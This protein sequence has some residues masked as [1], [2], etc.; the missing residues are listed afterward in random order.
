[1]KSR[2]SRVFRRKIDLWESVKVSDNFGGLK[3]ENRFVQNIWAS[4]RDVNIRNYD[5]AGSSQNRF[6]KQIIVRYSNLNTNIHFF[7]IGQKGYQ[8][9]DVKAN[10]KE[11]Q[12]ECI[13]EAT[14]FD[15]Q[16]NALR[17][18]F[19]ND[20]ALLIGGRAIGFQNG[21]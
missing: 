10:Y 15:I 2:I 1:M 7:V 21:S 3:V 4:V 18:L 20:R 11:N 16:P 12:F 14:N 13:C 8:I 19:I 5:I 6:E 9:N 17:A